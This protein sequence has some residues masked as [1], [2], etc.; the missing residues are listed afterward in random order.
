[1]LQPAITQWR[2]MFLLLA[3]LG[4]SRHENSEVANAGVLGQISV[5]IGRTHADACGPRSAPLHGAL[6]LQNLDDTQR[7]VIPAE[8]LVLHGSAKR[9]LPPGLYSLEWQA[10]TAEEPGVTTAWE[11]QRPPMLTVLPARATTVVVHRQL[12]R[13]AAVPPQVTASDSPHS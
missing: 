8:E 7:A 6:A 12:P 9:E 1:M 5:V 4:C 10:H 2:P 13:C 11:L 3:L